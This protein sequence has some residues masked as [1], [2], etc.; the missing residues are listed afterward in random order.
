MEIANTENYF[1]ELPNN[2][3]SPI[4]ISNT[5]RKNIHF[6]TPTRKIKD[7]YHSYKS[8]ELDPRPPFQRGYVWDKKKASRL[9][10]SILLNVPVPPIYTSQEDDL[11]EIVIDG[12]QRL[13]SLFSFVDEKF[14]DDESKFKLTGLQVL[15]ELNNKAFKELD[16]TIQRAFEGYGLQTIIIT[17]DSDIDVKF[18]IFGR[19]NTG[20]VKLNDQELRNCIYR[21]NYNDFIK[22]LSK[23]EDFQYILNSPALRERML[24]GELILRFFA[25][26]NKTYLN[27]KPSMKHFLNNEIH[28]NRD[29]IPKKM[30]ELRIIFKKSVELTKTVFGE[31]AFKRFMAGFSIDYN[32]KW[33]SNKV[34]RGLFD[35]LMFGFTR[36]EKS[37]IIPVADSIREELM[38]LLSN[39]YEFINSVSG[40]STDKKDSIELK[41][42][43]SLESLKKIVGTNKVEPRSFSF[44]LKEQL[45]RTDNTCSIC[46]QKIQTIDDSEIDHIDFYWEGGKTIEKNARLTH[47]YCNRARRDK[48]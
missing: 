2:E 46:N 28:S 39:N 43:I 40:S 21:G 23:D 44:S 18:E 22:E 32:G 41:F 45:Y 48:E 25:F 15:N 24:D 11:T 7:I 3:E 9:I 29:L 8:N 42:H 36:Y 16:K 33:E 47:R 19:L 5:K 31:R 1:D 34:N 37:Q 12:Q 20:S 17:K 35:V 38:W 10:E 6:L 26:Y 13:L 27:Y 14:P 30:E 4:Y